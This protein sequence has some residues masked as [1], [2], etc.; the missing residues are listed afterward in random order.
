MYELADAVCQ[1]CGRS[2]EFVFDI[3]QILNAGYAR[4]P[5]SE[6]W[7]TPFEGPY[8]IRRLDYERRSQKLFSE[9]KA[10]DVSE[11]ERQ[12]RFQDL[13]DDTFPIIN[14]RYQVSGVRKG[15]MGFNYLCSDR[16]WSPQ[17]SGSPFVVCKCLGKSQ[18]GDVRV[19]EVTIDAIT[20]EASVWAELKD[21]PNVVKM[22]ELLNLSATSL[23]L[24]LEAVLPGPQGRTTLQDWIDSGEILWPHT[25]RFARDLC[26]GMQ[27]CKKCLHGFVH[28]DLKPS[29]LL[30]DVFAGYRLKITD[31]GLSSGGNSEPNSTH[32]LGTPMY[33]APECWQGQERTPASDIYAIGLILYEMVI[34]KHPLSGLTASY[35]IKARHLSGIPVTF[36]LRPEASKFEPFIR[37]ALSVD[38]QS[39]P[40]LDELAQMLDI[41]NEPID[42]AS[43]AH[44]WN[45]E[46]TAL[47][48]LGK[49]SDAINCY[50]EALSR[51]PDG[52]ASWCNLALSYSK[53][54]HQEQAE[55]AYKRALVLAH[56]NADVHANHA[57]HLMRYGGKERLSDVVKCRDRAIALD[58]ECIAAWINKAAALNTQGNHQK[59]ADAA[60]SARRL[61]PVHSHSLFELATAYWK[62]GKR[63]QAWKLCD[64]IL[65][66]DPRFEPA[67]KLKQIVRKR[68]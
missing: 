26:R 41:N 11:E 21:H 50:V 51:D 20:R 4:N 47:T 57:A 38:S 29:N 36:E 2:R 3:T 65:C 60:L 12:K 55:R 43:T 30:I 14:G 61:S 16:R 58:A 13:I 63:H 5:F 8:G 1:A 33:L 7:P 18:D 53:C 48:A 25:L 34:G 19:D 44:E 42:E 6:T 62:L 32:G 64:K 56:T 23:V 67:R 22:L 68:P 28:G 66:I 35:E 40:S 27:H 49:H 59:A 9:A 46:G 31:F 54:G 52:S 37:R 15:A 10:G 24:V 17:T 39:R 45:N